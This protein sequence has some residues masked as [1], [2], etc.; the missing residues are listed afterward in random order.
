MALIKTVSLEEAE[1]NIREVY[2]K[3]MET[4]GMVPKPL[5]LSSASP[6]LFEHFARGLKYFM[7]HTTLG[8]PLL[9]HIRLLVAIES[10]YPYC[11]D[12][13]S[14]LLQMLGGL[15]EEQLAEVRQD[16]ARTTLPEKE[17]ALLLF[18]LKSVKTP[19]AVDKSDIDGLHELGWT[20]TDIFDATYHGANMITAGILFN[21]FKM[22]DV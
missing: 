3:L 2:S 7:T 16:P 21:A 12:L 18:V 14:M 5:E 9:A 17:K 10:E 11:I 19:E 13:N 1:G 22:G 15:S 20:D 4:A 6:A 8:L